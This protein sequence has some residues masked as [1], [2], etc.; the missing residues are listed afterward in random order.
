MKAVVSAGRGCA[1][2]A[3]L[4]LGLCV[5]PQLRSQ[6]VLAEVAGKWSGSLNVRASNG[7][8]QHDSAYFVLE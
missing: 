7:T 6:P 3:A 1:P 2:L 8:V 5:A 4:V